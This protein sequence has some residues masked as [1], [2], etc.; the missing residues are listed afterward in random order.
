MNDR[1][2]QCVAKSCF[3][4]NVNKG[5]KPHERQEKQHTEG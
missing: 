3:E 1:V 5:L 2:T 4:K